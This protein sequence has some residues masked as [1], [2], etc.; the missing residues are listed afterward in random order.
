MK[1]YQTIRKILVHPK[2]KINKQNTIGV[3]YN[4]PC[5]NC[6]SSYIGET[7]RSLG[8]RIN[9]HKKDVEKN[10]KGPFTRAARKESLTELNASAVTDHVN[11]NNHEINWENTQIIGKESNTLYRKVKEAIAIK[12]Q[13]NGMNR[14][15]GGRQLSWTYNPVIPL[16]EKRYRETTDS[17][18]RSGIIR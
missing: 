2:D 18:T 12:R 17:G 16:T 3:I 6:P 10:K 15:D 7:G 8:V 9:E 13:T 4:I 14:D 11:K 1:P 5:K